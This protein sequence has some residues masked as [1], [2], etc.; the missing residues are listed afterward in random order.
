[1]LIDAECT[2][3]LR[4]GVMRGMKQPAMI[5]AEALRPRKPGIATKTKGVEDKLQ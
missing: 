1:M 3:P 4:T 2:P 5:E